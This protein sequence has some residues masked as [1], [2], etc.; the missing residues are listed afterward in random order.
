MDRKTFNAERRISWFCIPLV[1]T[2]AQNRC[3]SFSCFSSPVTFVVA[4]SMGQQQHSWV[5]LETWCTKKYW[6]Y[7][8]VRLAVVGRMW[9]MVGFEL[10]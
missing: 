2:P 10:H 9:D 4:M 8:Y 5:M 7:I 6:E 1:K 3:S